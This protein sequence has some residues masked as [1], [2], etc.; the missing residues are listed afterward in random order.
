MRIKYERRC[1]VTV[2]G[3]EDIAE[4]L[5]L[6]KGQKTA[7]QKLQ[8]SDWGKLYASVSDNGKGIVDV[9]FYSDDLSMKVMT[10]SLNKNPINWRKSLEEIRTYQA[11][12][13]VRQRA[14]LKGTQRLI[15]KIDEVLK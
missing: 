9:V 3:A 5:N 6:N 2:V 4:V 15:A 8:E 7:L 12:R 10:V 13:E 14:K 1:Q 11:D